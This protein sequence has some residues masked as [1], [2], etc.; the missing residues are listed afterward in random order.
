MRIKLVF[1]RHI[2]KPFTG[3]NQFEEAYKELTYKENQLA[4]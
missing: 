3:S 2:N 4:S 1:L